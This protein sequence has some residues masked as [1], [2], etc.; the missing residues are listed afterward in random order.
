MIMTKEIFNLSNEM[1]KPTILYLFL[2]VLI[3][4]ISMVSFI[5]NTFNDKP[6]IALIYM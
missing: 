5:K 3:S 2:V 4:L 1:Q 6:I